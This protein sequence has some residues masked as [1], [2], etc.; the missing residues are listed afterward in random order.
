LELQPKLLRVLQG[1]EF[2][3]LYSSRTIQTDA[4]LVTASAQRASCRMPPQQE[5]WKKSSARTFSR[6]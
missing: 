6:R 5:R 2:E 3:R 4:R 1:R